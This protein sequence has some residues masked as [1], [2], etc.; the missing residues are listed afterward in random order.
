MPLSKEPDRREAQLAN[1]KRGQ[2]S[3]AGADA[4]RLVT[5]TQSE[6]LLAP[7]RAEAECWVRRRWPWLDDARVHLVFDAAARIRRVEIWCDAHDVL[8]YRGQHRVSVHPVVE[9]AAGWEKSLATWIDKLEAEARLR[10][11]ADAEVT[12][13]DLVD[14]WRAQLNGGVEE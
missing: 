9:T 13:E 1:L 5:G 12:A 3:P 2:G 14:A 10:A 11:K 4:R 8:H 6:V 7:L